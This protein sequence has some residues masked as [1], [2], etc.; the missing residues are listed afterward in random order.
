MVSPGGWG[1]KATNRLRRETEVFRKDTDS[2]SGRV[3]GKMMGIKLH[4]TIRMLLEPE[5]ETPEWR[6]CA[7]K[8][9]SSSRSCSLGTRW[10]LQGNPIRAERGLAQESTH[11]RGKGTGRVRACVRDSKWEEPW[12]PGDSF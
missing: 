8:S 1:K 4:G 10:Y 2:D 6:L 5:T 11:T 12:G 7:Y 9:H 3:E